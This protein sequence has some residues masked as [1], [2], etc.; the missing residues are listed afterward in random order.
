MQRTVNPLLA[1]IALAALIAP[2]GH[3]EETTLRWNVVADGSPGTMELA[4]A[5]GGRLQGT[6]MGRNVE[7]WLV[8]RHLVLIRDGQ[9]GPETWEAWLATPENVHGDER[10]ILAGTFTRP[11]VEGPLPWFG[12]TPGTRPVPLPPAGPSSPPGTAA[13]PQAPP[14]QP[15]PAGPPAGPPPGPPTAG[16]RPAAPPRPRTAAPRLPSG[17]PDIAGTWETPDGPLEILQDGSR[18]TFVLPGRNVEGRL[19]GPD[20]LIGGFGPGCC[21]GRLEQAFTVI[22]WDNGV[23]WYRR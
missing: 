14:P 23:R 7:G 12:T 8:G 17:Q 9:R 3:A 2:S 11:G 10:P 19:T 22:A 4:T 15:A 6:L 20:S 13:S 16:A 5:P 21:K 18:L 1:L